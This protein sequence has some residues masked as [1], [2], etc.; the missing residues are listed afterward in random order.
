LENAEDFELAA[1]TLTVI[2]LLLPN[3][4]ENLS[5]VFADT[6]IQ[7]AASEVLHINCPLLS[8]K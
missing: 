4:S 1:G 6:R 2:V 3:P 7:S 8:D 5:S